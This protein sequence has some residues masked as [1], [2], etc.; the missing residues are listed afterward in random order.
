MSFF[1]H[2]LQTRGNFVW[3]RFGVID[4]DD[5]LGRSQHNPVILLEKGSGYSNV[6]PSC[7]EGLGDLL[8]LV[9]QFVTLPVRQGELVDPI[10]S[11]DQEIFYLRIIYVCR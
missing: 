7:Q 6:S 11:V 8:N 2:G 3:A 9:G 4:I 1:H 5:D 10:P